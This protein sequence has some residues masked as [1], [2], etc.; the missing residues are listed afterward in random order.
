MKTLLFIFII[1]FLL[2]GCK[3]TPIEPIAGVTPEIVTKPTNEIVG[4]RWLLV[5]YR[6]TS[7]IGSTKSYDT[8]SFINN[9]EY[10]INN[11]VPRTYNLSTLVGSTNKSLQLNFFT[12]FGGSNYSGSVGNYF[13]SDGFINTIIYY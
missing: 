13:V 3:K 1:I 8:I 7:Y 4:T 5:E 12:P 11:G 2:F 10:K 6:N 9:T